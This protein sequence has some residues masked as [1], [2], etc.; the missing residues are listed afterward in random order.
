VAST[1]LQELKVELLKSQREVG[2]LS[3]QQSVSTREEAKSRREL[4][5]LRR[6]RHLADSKV[7][8][9]TCYGNVQGCP[10]KKGR[11]VIHPNYRF[12]IQILYACIF[13]AQFILPL[14]YKR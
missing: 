10:Q 2:Q 12:T 13:N 8:V 3:S 6:Q 11:A 7:K 9:S 1:K 5:E 4:E 14:F